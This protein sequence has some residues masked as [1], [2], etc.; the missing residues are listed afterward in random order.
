MPAPFGSG[1]LFEFGILE[2]VFETLLLGTGEGLL[3]I[4]VKKTND[5]LLFR[6]FAVFLGFVVWAVLIAGLI[7]LIGWLF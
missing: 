1:T 4:F 5:S 6:I 7:F 3:G 2:F